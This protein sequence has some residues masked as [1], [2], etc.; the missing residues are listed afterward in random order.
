MTS[1][2][3]GHNRNLTVPNKQLQVPYNIATITEEW[4]A[5]KTPPYLSIPIIEGTS[6]LM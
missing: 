2:L 3:L 5:E 6:L 4:H 1:G